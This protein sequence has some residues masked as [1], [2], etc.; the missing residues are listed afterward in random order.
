[1][2]SISCHVML[3]SLGVDTHIHT[4]TD[5]LDKSNFKKL[6]THPVVSQC[7]PGLKVRKQIAVF[8]MR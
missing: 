2:G 1:M 3:I 4:Y 6:A 7:V 5:F 8:E